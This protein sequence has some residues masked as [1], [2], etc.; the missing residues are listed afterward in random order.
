[1][2]SEAQ[3]T[4]TLY[5]A[6][7]EK[8]IYVWS[9]F[10]TKLEAR[11]RFGGL[12]YTAGVGSPRGAPKGKIPYIDFR[13]DNNAETEVIADTTLITKT[14]CERG[15]LADLNAALSPVAR[16]HDLALR[17]L[18]EEK[19]VFYVGWERWT[20]NY[21]TMRDHVLWP[22]PWPIR[23][24]V[25]LLAYR[26]NVATFHGQGTGRLTADEIDTFRLEIWSSFADLLLDSKTKSQ[27]KAGPFWVL[28][29]AQP[30]EADAS[31]FGMLSSSLISTASPK[32]QADV[33]SFPVLLDYARRVHE[34]YFPDY[35]ALLM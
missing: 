26:G 13:A 6:F 17:A 10:V 19:L 20:Q 9:P 1:M 4:I 33:K 31:L 22:I 16:A 27:D 34:R 18:L 2:S 30:T 11:L 14:L 23:V 24:L 12:S 5:R 28:G 32:S 8:G 7:Q 21:Y 25:G 35:E 29:G 15:V 3:P